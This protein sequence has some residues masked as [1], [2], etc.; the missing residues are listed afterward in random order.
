M[1][2]FNKPGAV[3][4][5]AAPAT[6]SSGDVV[7]VGSVVGVAATDAASAALVD[8][9][10]EGVFDLPKVDEQEWTVGARIY[11]DA[12]AEACTTV[13]STTA[14]ANT[15]IGVAVAAVADTAGLTTGRVLLTGAFT[16]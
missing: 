4:T 10:V 3:L 1:K 9:V 8:I 14:G 2:N 5:V 11:W 12:T 16:Q 15:L 6:V 7:K 13:A